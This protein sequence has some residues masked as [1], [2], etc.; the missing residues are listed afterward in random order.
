MRGAV[1]MAHAGDATKA[2]SQFYITLAPA[3]AL[4]GKFTV[5]G[6]VLSGMDVAERIAVGDVLKKMS[7][8]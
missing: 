8:K 5:F 2:D 7:V 4:N 3:P 6:R 1:A